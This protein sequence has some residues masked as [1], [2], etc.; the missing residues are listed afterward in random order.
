MAKKDAKMFRK[1]N[2]FKETKMGHEKREPKESSTT[3]HNILH[4]VCQSMY[5]YVNKNKLE[6]SGEEEDNDDTNNDN[7]KD[8][9]GSINKDSSDIEVEAPDTYIAK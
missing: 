2:I 5:E 9:G 7:N 4:F 8:S 6:M 1:A 3:I